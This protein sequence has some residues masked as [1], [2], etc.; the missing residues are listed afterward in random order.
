MKKQLQGIAVIL[1]G[2][3][4]AIASNALSDTF[5]TSEMTFFLVSIIVGAVG[6]V[7][8]FRSDSKA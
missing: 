6:V 1:F 2:I 4:L 7:M 8:A 5:N 3:L